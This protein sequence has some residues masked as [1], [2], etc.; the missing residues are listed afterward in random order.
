MNGQYARVA[1][2]PDAFH[3]VDGVA[4][5]ARNFAAYARECD[6]PLLIVHAGLGDA[7]DSGRARDPDGTTAQPH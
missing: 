5:V 3:E 2:F 6:I 1:Y 4:I 7:V